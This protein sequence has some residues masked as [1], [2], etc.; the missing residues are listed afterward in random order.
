[1]LQIM[2]RHLTSRDWALCSHGKTLKHAN[3][4]TFLAGFCLNTNTYRYEI[5]KLKVINSY[6]VCTLPSVLN[7]R[8][9]SSSFYLHFSF[10]LSFFAIQ[11][12]F[13]TSKMWLNSFP[14]VTRM[15]LRIQK[16]ITNFLFRVKQ[17]TFI[18]LQGLP[19]IMLRK[20]L[21]SALAETSSWKLPAGLRQHHTITS[22]YITALA[23]HCEINDFT[24]YACC[25][26]FCQNQL[27]HNTSDC[28]LMLLSSGPVLNLPVT[29]DPAQHARGRNHTPYPL[30]MYALYGMAQE[31]RS[32]FW[33]V[34]V[35]VI[36]SEKV[37]MYICPI[38]NGFRDWYFT[39]KFQ[40]C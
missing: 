34:T 35:S 32:I 3:V 28:R 16:K 7:S 11:H 27:K 19:F 38:P 36:L 33:V 37:Y 18:I 39:I 31:E 15:F 24:E 10:F 14:F 17:D 20:C 21:E 5:F 30:F 8:P 4:F 40:N 9:V 12:A 25:T 6:Y 23:E 13:M 1:M 29:N 2:A 22:L 26:F